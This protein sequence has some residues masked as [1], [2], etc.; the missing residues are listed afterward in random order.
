MLHQWHYIQIFKEILT[1]SNICMYLHIIKDILTTILSFSI[2]FFVSLSIISSHLWHKNTLFTKSTMNENHSCRVK[3]REGLL[4]I[5]LTGST[6]SSTREKLG[7]HSAPPIAVNHQ[8][9]ALDENTTKANIYKQVRW[10]CLANLQQH[11]PITDMVRWDEMTWALK[12]NVRARLTLDTGVE[13]IAI[14]TLMFKTLGS[15]DD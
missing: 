10:T 4:F 14:Y 12:N 5:D 2:T 15:L 1:D 11:N 8:L 3:L 7:Y 13:A 9:I 6:F